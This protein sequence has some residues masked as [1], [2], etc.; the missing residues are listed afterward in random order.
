M[1]TIG[2]CDDQPQQ[3]QLLTK[4]LSDYM[5]DSGD[6]R[7]IASSQPVEFLE[8]LEGVRAAFAFLDICMGDMDG[9]RLGEAIRA[10][11][12][13]TMLIY[14]SAFGQYALDA[15]RVRA[16][17]YLLK[18]VERKAFN[19]LM[20]EML[21]RLSRRDQ[22]ASEKHFAVRVKGEIAR[23][24]YGEIL[25]FEKVGHRVVVHTERRDLSYY[26]NMQTLLSELDSDSFAQ[27]HQGYV[28]NLNR[29]R[30]FRDRTLKLD[31]GAEVPV[32]R[33]YADHVKDILI[34]RLFDREESI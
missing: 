9:I 12:R 19:A 17:H 24:A 34:K 25:Y 30:A 15:F 1:L 33:S 7:V 32:S 4:Y 8:M 2:I 23:F 18:P 11:H 5:G 22:A 16:F 3:V 6:Y 21:E 20:Q 28:V 27:C 13:E 14:T 29:V 26:G 10:K 31:G